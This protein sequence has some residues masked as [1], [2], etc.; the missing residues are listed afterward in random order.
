M[1]FYGNLSRTLYSGRCYI[2]KSIALWMCVHQFLKQPPLPV[3]ICLLGN[4]I[5]LAPCPY[6]HP[7]AAAGNNF[8]L[9]CSSRFCLDMFCKLCFIPLHLSMYQMSPLQSKGDIWSLGYYLIRFACRTRH[10]EF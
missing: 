7:A 10:E 1:N 9:H 8:L 6:C 5:F 3:V 2:H 4:A